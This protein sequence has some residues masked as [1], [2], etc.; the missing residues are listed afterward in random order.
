MKMRPK[1][2]L[3]K[4]DSSSRS[5]LLGGLERADAAQM[6]GR[7]VSRV[8]TIIA[9]KTTDVG[10]SLLQDMKAS[11]SARRDLF[12]LRWR[13]TS[14]VAADCAVAQG[15]DAA[16]GKSGWR[17]TGRG[18]REIVEA[19]SQPRRLLTEPG[20]VP[21][22]HRAIATLCTS[23]ARTRI[24]RVRAEW[25]PPSPRQSGRCGS[26]LM[27]LRLARRWFLITMALAIRAD[28]RRRRL[29]QPVER[30]PR[31]SGAHDGETGWQ[32]AI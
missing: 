31:P 2:L 8:R 28:G 11:S 14:A 13:S 9:E 18:E 5:A 3:G 32:A 1:L 23:R 21:S 19:I 25:R 16:F 10:V 24:Q 26:K 20:R 12:E 7:S 29:D 17:N 27:A 4:W 30:D 6:D 22:A 15:F